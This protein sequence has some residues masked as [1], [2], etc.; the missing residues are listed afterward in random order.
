MGA[1]TD[2]EDNELRPE[3]KELEPAPAVPSADE[4]DVGNVLDIE[5]IRTP[6]PGIVTVD[7]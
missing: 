5:V 7:I 3:A 6:A 4:M 1:V 2:E